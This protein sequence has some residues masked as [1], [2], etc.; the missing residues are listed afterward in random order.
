M[1]G[2]LLFAQLKD[3]HSDIA[4]VIG[5]VVLAARRPRRERLFAQIAPLGKRQER[6]HERARQRDQVRVRYATRHG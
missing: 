2:R 1:Q 3:F 6:H 4:V 5:A